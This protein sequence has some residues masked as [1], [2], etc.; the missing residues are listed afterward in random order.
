MDIDCVICN[1]KGCPICKYTGWLEFRARA[2]FT[3][4]AEYGGYDPAEFSGFAFGMGPDRMAM[5]K[6]GMTIS[7]TSTRTIHAISGTSWMNR[8]FAAM[9]VPLPW[10]KEYVDLVTSTPVM[11]ERITLAGLGV[12]AIENTGDWWDAENILIGRIC[13]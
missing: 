9:F 10:L 3:R 12:E 2:W 4:R 5:Q 8:G 1:G 6:Y 7:A 13:R 11:A